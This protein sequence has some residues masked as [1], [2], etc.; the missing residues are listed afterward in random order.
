[1]VIKW[2]FKVKDYGTDKARLVLFGFIQVPGVDFDESHTPVVNDT[3]SCLVIIIIITK[4]YWV[5]R[6]LDV[7]EEFLKGHVD[8]ELY[9][10]FPRGMERITKCQDN[11]EM[12]NKSIYG[13]VQASR[14]FFITLKTHL[15][16]NLFL[17]NSHEDPCLFK[18]KSNML[19][20]CIYVDDL[21]VIGEPELVN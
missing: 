21:L 6:Q 9:I 12:L 18:N 10:K 14:Q 2:V 17:K 13:L 1:M 8:E 11:I 3:T 5:L 7:K 19:M 16:E 15:K 4:N 20:I